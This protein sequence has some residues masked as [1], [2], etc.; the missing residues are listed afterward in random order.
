MPVLF[1]GIRY[2]EQPKLASPRIVTL[3]DRDASCNVVAF[4]NPVE[5]IIRP[6]I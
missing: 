6:Y 3:A 1:G 4:S 2:R 5:P